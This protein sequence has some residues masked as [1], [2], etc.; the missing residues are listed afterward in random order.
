MQIKPKLA[1]KSARL[2][3]PCS[4]DEIA[5][6]VAD[7]KSNGNVRVFVPFDCKDLRNL[8][9]GITFPQELDR[10]A[11]R[12][13]SRLPELLK[14]AKQALRLRIE[15]GTPE[16]QVLGRHP[17]KRQLILFAVVDV[18]IE[19]DPEEPTEVLV[20]GFRLVLTNRLIILQ[21]P[22]ADLLEQF[23]SLLAVPFN[24][25]ADALE[26]VFKFSML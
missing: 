11:L 16:R 5:A 8:S 12:I 10:A 14:L 9:V 22:Y 2:L 21:Y 13:R 20:C 25:A 19:R 6:R 17:I 23:G 18:D 24:A 7:P 15:F 1:L 4:F 3:D 26:S